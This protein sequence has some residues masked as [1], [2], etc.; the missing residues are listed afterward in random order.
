[1]K[2]VIPQDPIDSLMTREDFIKK[3][4]ECVNSENLRLV[5]I[6]LYNITNINAQAGVHILNAISMLKPI[7]IADPALAQA[8]S[9]ELNKAT[10]CLTNLTNHFEIEKAMGE[11]L[12]ATKH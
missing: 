5:G 1:M 6:A 11:K 12:H 8:I 4:E 9:G 2:V 7:A 10:A 3:V